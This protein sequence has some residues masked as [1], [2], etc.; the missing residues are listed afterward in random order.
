[1]RQYLS[2]QAKAWILFAAIAFIIAGLVIAVTF[3]LYENLY[4]ESQAAILEDQV[5]ELQEVYKEEGASAFE[6]RFDWTT[7]SANIEGVLTDNPMSLGA[8]MPLDHPEEELVINP[9]ERSRLMDGETVIL[10]RAHE[11]LDTQILGV[12]APIEDHGYLEAVILLY[13]P[14]AD[15]NEAFYHLMPIIGLIIVISFFLLF[16]LM[17]RV[18]QEFIRPM[19]ELENHAKDLAKG[20][21]DRTLNIHVENEIADLA[22]SFRFLAKILAEEDEKK[23]AFIQNISHELRTPLSYIRGYSELLRDM[24]IEKEASLHAEY[25]LIIYKETT[26]MNRLVDQLI[27]LTRLERTSSSE[28]HFTPLVLAEL[29]DEALANTQLKRSQKNQELETS[30]D[31]E[32]IVYGEEDRL[33]Q[34]FINLLDNASLYTGENGRI[35]VTTFTSGPN[36]VITISDNGIGIEP[37]MLPYLTERFFRVETS[38]SR[39]KGGSGIGLSI[40]Q[41]IID[42]HGGELLFHSEKGEGTTVEVHLPLIKD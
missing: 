15:L 20:K 38:R 11:A 42:L 24:D 37:G 10:S 14:V 23:R 25:S 8:A 6:E 41:Q 3:Y 26:R 1:M 34:V 12:A 33:L 13:R 29:I 36:A 7:Q 30:F 21:Y 4:M 28:V 19:L 39:A 5:A 32:A 16:I 2:V 27:T 18:Q 22:D 17:K 35:A 31:N 40:V 9:D